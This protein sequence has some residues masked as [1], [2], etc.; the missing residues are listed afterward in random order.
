MSTIEEAYLLPQSVP[1][2]CAFTR[3]DAVYVWTQGGY[4]VSRDPDDYPLFL[5]VR[6]VDRP[7]WERFFEGAG[8]PTAD[9][10]QPRED[11]DGPL[12][13][14][15]ES[16]SELEIDTVEGYPVTPLDET[17]EYMHE[18]YAHFQSAIR[19]VEEMYDDR[20]PRA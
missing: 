1:W 17:L 2:P 5:A 20:F 13:V 3:I 19:M 9:E 6:E 7:E 4:Q 14:V 10:R 11:L 8:L 16:R 18:N 15:L 12:Q